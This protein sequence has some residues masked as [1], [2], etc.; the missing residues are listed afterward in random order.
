M[1]A[2][3]PQ[4]CRNAP[5][6]LNMLLA[7]SYNSGHMAGLAV[8]GEI[9]YTPSFLEKQLETALA[10]VEVDLPQP[11][12]LKLG[13]YADLGC[14]TLD[15]WR[16]VVL[17]DGQTIKYLKCLN[18]LPGPSSGSRKVTAGTY[19]DALQHALSGGNIDNETVFFQ[20]GN[21][22]L[23]LYCEHDKAPDTYLSGDLKLLQDATKAYYAH[24]GKMEEA[25]E[26]IGR[27][28]AHGIKA[29]GLKLTE[30]ETS[31]AI[32]MMVY[33]L[34]SSSDGPDSS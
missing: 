26:F 11:S 28:K 12:L 33:H 24:S 10:A 19:L 7:K 20:A 2:R 29:D 32:N 30:Q 25:D 17:L 21:R 34:S 8:R 6:A 22:E 4:T 27:C 31:K 23:M 18:V 5:K 14:H 13:D 16:D 1:A 9:A 3:L 15:L